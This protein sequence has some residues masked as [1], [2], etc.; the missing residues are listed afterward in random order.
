MASYINSA[1][2][3]HSR[4]ALSFSE[5]LSNYA[6]RHSATMAAKNKLYHNSYLA[7]W[8]SNWNW[9]IL[10]ENVGV[11]STVYGLHRAFMASPGHKA[12]IMDR[13]FRNVGVGIVSAN[14]RIW[15]TIIFR[16]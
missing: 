5:G 15:V 6:R 9:R 3:N 8:L 1:R 7:S 11:G 10:G 12:N 2:T 14:G 16:G 13:R 4:A